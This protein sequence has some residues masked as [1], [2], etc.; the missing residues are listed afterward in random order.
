MKIS[1][2]IAISIC[3]IAWAFYGILVQTTLCDLTPDKGAVFFIFPSLQK[4]LLTL[5]IAQ[6]FAF[7]LWLTTSLVA[8][9]FFNVEFK[10]ALAK[11]VV[12]LYPS[13]FL[14][15]LLG[16]FAPYVSILYRLSKFLLDLGFIFPLI[17]LA[18]ILLKG[19][20]PKF[21]VERSFNFV[22]SISERKLGAILFIFALAVYVFFTLRLVAPNAPEDDR[23]Y[24]LTGDEPH[25]LL[26]VHSLVFDRDFNMY[27]N[28]VEGHS[29][30]YWNRIANGFSGGV[31]LFGKYARG[32]GVTA[33]A[34]YWKEKRYSLFRLGFPLLLCPLYYLGYL[35]DHQ[36]RLVV[37]LFLNLVTA[38]L[39]WNVF[40][41]T[42]YFVGSK[43]PATAGALWGGKQFRYAGDK[44]SAAT[45]GEGS[46]QRINLAKEKTIA[47]ISTLFFALSMPVL[48]YSCRIYTEIAGAL[49]IIYAFRKIVMRETGIWNL[50]SIG[51]CIAFLPWLHDKYIWFSALLLGMFFFRRRYNL[52]I[53]TL[54][55]FSAPI[56]IS[57][58]FLMKYYYLLFG[59]FYPVNM[60]PGFSWRS[61]TNAFPGLIL[62]QDH[63][64]LPYSP[65]YFFALPGAVFMWRKRRND[66][67]WL[68]LFILSFYIGTASFKEWWGGFCPPGRYL[69]PVLGLCIPF[70]GCGIYYLGK[71][72]WSY[73]IF[74]CLSI[75]L[76]FYSMWFAG[77]LYRHLHPFIPYVNWLNLRGLFP[78]MTSPQSND[79]RLLVGWFFVIALSAIFV[80]VGNAKG[81]KRF[82]Y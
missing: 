19:L 76:G 41:L 45:V 26:V 27:N 75:A 1:H 38:L 43:C 8:K 31:G 7:C 22:N 47:M 36:I 15:L 71:A 82:G 13:L 73:H 53:L 69:V 50:F 62:D 16:L 12:N 28:F 54:I 60:H 10:E 61:F 63:G 80:V 34:E 6:V 70:V 67:V 64:L 48:F 65:F 32:R 40:H 46:T 51:L 23:Y 11:R 14:F 55:L 25:Y 81:N 44:P 18:L 58:C 29:R 37:L 59:A 68:I 42:Y 78:R 52:R 49:L 74:G 77:R 57:I 20:K 35:W 24:L 2:I 39:V 17:V 66:A 4:I 9:Q 72:R 79:Y 5:I 30:I 56:L 33:T 3:G 21:S